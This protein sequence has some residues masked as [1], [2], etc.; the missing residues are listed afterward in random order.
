MSVI[1]LLKQTTDFTETDKRIVDFILKNLESIPNLTITELAESTYTSHS[2]IIRLAQKLHFKGYREFKNAL[3]KASILKSNQDQQ[4]DNNFP[5]DEKSTDKEITETLANLTQ[6]TITETVAQL[7]TQKLSQIC[8]CLLKADKIMIYGQGDSQ[9][10][11]RYF[12]N[13]LVKLNK[14]AIIPE[15]YREEAWNTTN[16]TV[17]DCALFISYGGMMKHY[18]K[19]MEY[20]KSQHVPIILLTGN[21]Q[22]D[23]LRFATYS[24]ITDNNELDYAKISPFSSQVGFEFLLNCIY[25]GMFKR[26]FRKNIETLNER[27]KIIQK[28]ILADNA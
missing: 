19:I 21:P 23:L 8:D 28:G 5:F 26:N 18:T 3:I 15:E 9:I 22:T 27:Q 13:K 25:A 6:N 10:L 20:L 4:I 11:A 17:N 12:Q 7:D 16:L 14:I 24:L 1:Q 2:A